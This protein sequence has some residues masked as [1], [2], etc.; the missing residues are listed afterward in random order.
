LKLAAEQNKKK[1]KI[2]GIGGRSGIS[3]VIVNTN[4]SCELW[5]YQK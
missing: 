3:L 2:S 1:K 4:I 5:S